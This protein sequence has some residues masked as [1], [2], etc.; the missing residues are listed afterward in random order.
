[1][2]GEKLTRIEEGFI[3]LSLIFLI[4]DLAK[5]E[6]EDSEFAQSLMTCEDICRKLGIFEDFSRLRKAIMKSGPRGVVEIL[7][8]IRMECEQ[9]G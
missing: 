1:M 2:S 9:N 8:T 4:T 6:A 3:L 7:A 5:G